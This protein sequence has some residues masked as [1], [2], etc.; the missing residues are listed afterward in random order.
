MQLARLEAASGREVVSLIELKLD[1][2]KR[3]ESRQTDD[4]AVA[5]LEVL[6]GKKSL[7]RRVAPGSTA[8]RRRF[9]AL[10]AGAVTASIVDPK[11]LFADTREITV[12]ELRQ[13]TL[14]AGRR[15]EL[16]SLFEREFIESQ[17]AVGAHV[18]GI[19]RDLDDPDRFVWMR[20]FQDLPQRRAALQGFYTGPVWRANSRAANETM[21]DSANV[22]LLR[23]LPK[24]AGLLAPQRPKPNGIV[25]ISI[26]NLAAVPPQAFADFFEN[27]MR[28]MIT[29]AGGTVL[30]ELISESQPNDFPRLPVREHESVFVWLTRLAD[31]GAEAKFSQLLARRSGWRDQV[32]ESL[33][34]ALMRK[35]EVLR[36]SPTPR[37]SLG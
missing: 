24:S 31:A 1:I 12:V 35:P 2:R 30:A 5:P 14:R 9:M 11:A 33:W 18:L 15:E 7:A 36:L 32:P 4:I 13:Y 29:E 19:F 3:S 16:T 25:R 8:D 23:P 20:G 22:L 28:P 10:A 37:S 6:M 26:H 17:E 34:P 21:L 27:T